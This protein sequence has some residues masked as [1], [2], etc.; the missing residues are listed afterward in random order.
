MRRSSKRMYS[1]IAE[2]PIGVERRRIVGA[3]VEHDLVA[4]AQQL[5]GDG[6]GHRGR[7]AAATVV[8]VGQDVAD[9]GEPRRR[10]DDVRARRGDERAVDPD[11]VVDA[12]GDRLDGSHEAKPS[13]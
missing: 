3:D 9:D 6:A 1:T 5:G 4:R 10:A 2:P 11:A 8:D 12:V 7:E 13:W